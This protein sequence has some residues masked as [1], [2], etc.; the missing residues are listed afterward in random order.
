[1]RAN[2]NSLLEKS[3]LHCSALALLLLISGCGTPMPSSPPDSRQTPVIPPLSQ[4]ARQRAQPSDQYLIR[5]SQNIEDWAT[6]LKSVSQTPLTPASSASAPT[7]QS[8]T[9]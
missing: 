4:S 5:V 2:V 7:I 6:T 8:N 3:S 1:M 9:R